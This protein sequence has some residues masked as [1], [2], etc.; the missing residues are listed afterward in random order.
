MLRQQLASFASVVDT[1]AVL[2]ET[3]LRVWQ[4]APRLSGD[5]KPN[6]L[7]RHAS[8][9]QRNLAISEMRRIGNQSSV[10]DDAEW[11]ELAYR[12][13]DSI[14]VDDALR[15]AVLLCRSKLSGTPAR[16]IQARLEDEGNHADRELAQVL[17]MRVN[18]FLQNITRARRALAECLRLAGIDLEVERR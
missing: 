5:G 10:L 15:A 14:V 4:I 2:Q 6:A 11:D 8:R 13:S 3:L 7:L 12:G 1:E 9:M 17:G 16:A 18:T